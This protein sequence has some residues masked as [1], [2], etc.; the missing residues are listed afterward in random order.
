MVGS[1]HFIVG[2]EITM[3]FCGAQNAGKFRV[4]SHTRLRARDHYTPSTL[5]GGKGES[6]PSSLRTT[7]A[8]GTNGVSE[9][10]QGECKKST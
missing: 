9:W 2:H 5:I 1:P 3:E 6:S 8:W 7:D 10:M 4:T